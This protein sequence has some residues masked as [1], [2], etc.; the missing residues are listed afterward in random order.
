MYERITDGELKLLETNVPEHPLVVWF[1][2]QDGR[3]T[4]GRISGKRCDALHSECGTSDTEAEG[5]SRYD[6]KM[7]INEKMIL[8]T[9]PTAA[10]C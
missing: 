2:D 1:R 7:H 3:K 10:A 8:D 6:E 4:P 5:N 9:V